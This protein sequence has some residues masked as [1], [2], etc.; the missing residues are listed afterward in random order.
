MASGT[1]INVRFAGLASAV[2][3]DR[4][5]VEAGMRICAEDLAK[6]TANTGVR[7]RHV[8]PADVC[9]SDLCHAAAERLLGEMGWA[10]DS[11]DLLVFVSQTPDYVLPATSCVLHGRLGLSKACAAFDISLGCSGYVYALNI[12]GNMVGSGAYRRALL[13][14]GDT[15]SKV[16]SR[17]DRSV[18]YLFGDAGTATTLEHMV[19]AAPMTFELGTDGS[20]WEHLRI[21]AGGF[22]HR[23]SAE[24]ALVKSREAGNAR[25]DDHLFMN[26][27]EIFN[28]TLREIPGLMKRLLERAGWSAES[29]DWWVMHQANRFML[30]YLTKR[31]KLPANKAVV[32]LENHG[33]TSSASIPLAMSH[34]LRETITGPGQTR[35]VL[36]G[37]G[38][39]FSWAAATVTLDK[40]VA[41]PVIEVA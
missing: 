39:G 1:V 33:N 24:S 26:G 23:P 35:L 40:V 27:A 38:V 32:A 21:P 11:V 18:A 34:K 15:I 19:G 5:A 16:I 10:K 4:Q 13:L 28:F 37:F 22:R 25:A 2:P 30:D 29:V 3:R 41:P 17:E 36:A 20:G 9:T 7:Q 31:M 6:V 12:V 8:A 14:V